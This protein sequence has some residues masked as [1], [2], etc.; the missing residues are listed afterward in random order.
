M[1]FACLVLESA[2]GSRRNCFHLVYFRLGHLVVL[3]SVLLSPGNIG[4]ASVFLSKCLF[5]KR[6]AIGPRVVYRVQFKSPG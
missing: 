4:L 2:G 6:V 1:K 5:N 3:Q